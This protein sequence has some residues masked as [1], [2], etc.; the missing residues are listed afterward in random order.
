MFRTCMMFIAA[1][2]I[3][4]A[5]AGP[6]GAQTAADAS[7]VEVRGGVA[8][9]DV[10]TNI[11]A[12]SVHG[13]SSALTAR[14]RLRQTSDGPVLERIEAAVPVKTLNTGMGMRD[15]HMRKHIFTTGD[16]Q[17]PDLMFTADKAACS[18]KAARQSTCELSGTLVIRGTARPFAVTM[19][20]TEDGDTIRAVGDSAVTLSAYGIE[21]PSQ[22]GVKTADAV[23]LRF[24][25]TA[26]VAPR[27]V[28][29]SGD[30]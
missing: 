25:L 22:L 21:R 19:K 30:R 12:I 28:A 18:R 11:S 6:A 2:A 16:G 29:T 15:E 7:S 13:K 17:L 4:L 24:E 8:A 3:G 1:S 10:D 27:V 23:K 9:F 20:L 5:L 14:L 26:N